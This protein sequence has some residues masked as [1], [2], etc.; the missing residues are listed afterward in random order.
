M[1]HHFRLF[2]IYF[3]KQKCSTIGISLILLILFVL[4]IGKRRQYEIKLPNESLT[5][6][7]DEDFENLNDKFTTV[8]SICMQFNNSNSVR[9][10]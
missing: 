10:K 5:T 2:S 8:V 3:R 1:S 9:N 7:S 6:S 4:L